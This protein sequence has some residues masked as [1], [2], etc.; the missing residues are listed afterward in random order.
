MHLNQWGASD[1]KELTVFPLR[2]KGTKRV[3][4]KLKSIIGTK[5]LRHSRILN[6]NLCD[7]VGDC[8]DNLRAIVEKVD[9]TH[10]SLIINKHNI[11]TITQNRRGKRETPN[12]T[13]K[14]IKRCCEGDA[15]MTRVRR[16]MM[17]AQLT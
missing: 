3:L 12:I 6:D 13:V 14:K 9:P 4:E 16:S 7:E 1:V 17:F 11:V 8:S 10:T 2:T 5:N 15:I